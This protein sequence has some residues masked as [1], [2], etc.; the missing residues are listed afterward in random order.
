M[1]LAIPLLIAWLVPACAA[2]AARAPHERHQPPL[3]LQLDR[4]GL[5]RALRRGSDRAGRT[6]RAGYRYLPSV[7]P[8][9]LR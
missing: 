8:G 6:P 9:Y 7:L 4:R 1:R 2:S 3:R 5:L